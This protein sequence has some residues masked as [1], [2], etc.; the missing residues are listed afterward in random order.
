ME[1][2]VAAWLADPEAGERIVHVER[3]PE[4]D[5]IHA[6]LDAPLPHPLGERLSRL[7][8]D[9]LFR[10]QVMA[11]ERVRAGRHTVVVAGTASGKS[12]CYQI[13]IAEAAIGDGSATALALY[14]TKALTQDQLRAFSELGVG[15]LVPATY[16]GDSPPDKRQW[17]RRNA[18]VVLTNP[19]MLHVGILPHHGRWADFFWRLRYVVVDELHVFRGIFGSHVAHI[20]RRLRRIAAR[21]GAHPTFVFCSATIGNPGELAERLIGSEVSVVDQD[22]SPAGEKTWVLWNPP[23]TDEEEGIRAS[24]LGEATDVFVDLIRREVPT[25]AFNRSRKATELQYRWAR[26]R[27]DDGKADRI[28]P[29]RGGY[30]AADRRRVE[31]ALFSGELLGVTATEALELG[32]DVGGLDAAVINTFPGT[33]ASLRQ[34]AGRAGRARDTSLAVLVGGQDALDQY[35]LTHPEELFKRAPEAA[36]V[37]PD[38]PRILAA[39]MGCA[40]FELPLVPADREFLGNGMEEAAPQLVEEGDLRLRQ[41]KLYWAN[42]KAPAPAI[43]IRTSAGATYSIVDNSTGELLGLVDETKAFRQAHPGAVYLH[44]GDSYVVLD[45]DRAAAD[46]RVDRRDVGYYTQPKEDKHLEII[47]TEGEK[48][49]GAFEVSLGVVEVES[50]VIAYRRKEIKT[51]AILDTEPLDLPP[52]QFTTQAFWVEVPDVLYDRAGL[53]WHDVPGTLHAAEHTGIAM[54]PL[55]AICDRWDVG[56]LSTALHPGLGRGVWFI[57][58]GYAGGAGISPI[59]FERIE[60]LLRSTLDALQRC[61]C[62][63]GCPS[64]AQSPKCGNFNDPLD[65]QGAAKLIEVGLA[66]QP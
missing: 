29:Y 11:I 34:Q 47:R 56:G 14:P 15:A 64:C 24:S 3:V 46:I 27:L 8:I 33:I 23:L 35:Y 2:V 20:L 30:L 65:K 12:L 62:A 38:N 32:I 36:V 45:L 54:L 66:S 5:A 57:Y 37:N 26:D 51:G 39:H 40:A 21:Y 58:D 28:A 63:S 49:V 42:R 43:N 19:D 55:F 18:N 4:R 52:T 41:G 31:K 44:Q 60:E 7:G 22:D 10:H 9:R 1:A 50:H 53:E 25:I 17:V 13:P 6:D 48:R 61:P 16:D 59:G